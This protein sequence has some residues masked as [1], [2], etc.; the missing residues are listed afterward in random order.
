[1]IMDEMK[2]IQERCEAFDIPIKIGPFTSGASDIT[3]NPFGMPETP[4]AAWIEV[5]DQGKR[6]EYADNAM[7]YV[8]YLIHLRDKDED[9]EEKSN[10]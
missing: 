10:K 6:F 4:M 7:K 1:M 3:V 5:G 8:D 9:D 2:W